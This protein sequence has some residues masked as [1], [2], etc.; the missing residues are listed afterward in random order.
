VQTLVL[1]AT[2][3]SATGAQR[4]ELDGL[5]FDGESAVHAASAFAERTYHRA[6]DGS[7]IDVA[8]L[9]ADGI[10]WNGETLAAER[11]AAP[12]MS[13][14]ATPIRASFDTV[15]FTSA[16]LGTGGVREL[17]SLS[18]TSG[19][20]K[21]DRVLEWSAGVLALD[22]YHAP[23][24]GETTLDFVETREVELAGGVNEAHLRADRVAAR[25]TRIDASGETVFAN[26]EVDGVTLDDTHGRVKTSALALR[27][28]PL[29]IRE[30]AVEIGTLSLSGID[31]ALGLS[32]SGDWELPALPLP[33]GTGNAQSSFRVRMQEAS[34]AAPGSIIRFIDRTTEPDFAESLAIGSAALRGFDSEAIGVPARFSFEATAG[35]FSALQA[36]GVLVPTLTGTEFDLNTT[37]RGL[38]LRALSPYS[39]LHLGR[40][41]EGGHADVMLDATIRTSDLEGVADFTLNEVALGE[42]ELPAGSLGLGA[43]S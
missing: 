39:R 11:G 20:G 1:N 27:A 13:I 30:S 32:E 16:R 34:T 8:G 3:D 26:A 15:A 37:I 12:L 28:S 36:D 40:P 10:E 17:G 23:G 18:S 25:G 6:S 21:V 29:T 42:S 9:R 4:V 31:S 22:G 33:L 19:R 35:S 43:V 24:Y 7:G 41:V 2:G 14:T 5:V 38:S